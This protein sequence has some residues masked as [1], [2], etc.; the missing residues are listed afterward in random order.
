[1]ELGITIPLQKRLK[2]KAPPYGQR[3]DLFFC[4]ELHVIRLQ[5][6]D[7]LVAVNGANRF[8]VVLWGMEKPQWDSLAS[9]TE[10]GI[11]RGFRS[12]GYT[13]RQIDMY[14]NKA[15]EMA[16]TKTHGRRPVAML[17]RM[18]EYLRLL[19]IGADKGELYQEAHCHNVNREICH[20]AGFSDY[21]FPVEF[22]GEDMKRVGILSE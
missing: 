18:V 15:A 21:G 11:R 2:I 14:F 3:I 10:E 8:G 5:G 6:R 17:N 20:A 19:P 16:I 7:T 9:V 1:M 12:E 4:W 22:L 13:K